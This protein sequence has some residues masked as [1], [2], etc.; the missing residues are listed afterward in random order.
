[1]PL[2]L[3]ELASIIKAVTGW[4]DEE[5][6]RQIGTN[7]KYVSLMRRGKLEPR[8]AAVFYR[9]M[10][11][12]LSKKF[13]FP[14]SSQAQA[15]IFSM[16]QLIQEKAFDDFFEKHGFSG[17]VMFDHL[18]NIGLDES[19]VASESRQTVLLTEVQKTPIFWGEVLIG[20]YFVVALDHPD[21][22]EKNPSPIEISDKDR[23]RVYNILLKLIGDEAKGEEEEAWRTVL[24]GKVLQLFLAA[25]W[26]RLDAQSDARASKEIKKWVDDLSL[27]ERL[28]AYND[29]VPDVYSAPFGAL[30]VASRFKQRDRYEDALGR[31]QK[32][33]IEQ[34]FNTLEG[35]F[36]MRSSDG[37]SD[38]D[39]DF[40]DFIAWAE[41]NPAFFKTMEKT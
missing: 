35:I 25:K 20:F 3:Q 28:I 22:Q 5:F 12:V 1:M 30:A 38:F 37:D 18:L 6:A 41:E 23:D 4:S 17:H 36:E 31:L 24:R 27:Q 9:N 8:Q 16:M 14:W 32:Q 7:T 21:A 11:N 10:V 33:N 39:E 40:D 15:H 13:T 19:E 2:N 34:R 26:N 29:F